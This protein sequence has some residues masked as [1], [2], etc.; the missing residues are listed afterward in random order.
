MFTML[1]KGGDTEVDDTATSHYLCADLLP[2][3]WTDHLGAV[4]GRV[5]HVMRSGAT[6]T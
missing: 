5:F 6:S 4:P 2:A 1:A 3:R